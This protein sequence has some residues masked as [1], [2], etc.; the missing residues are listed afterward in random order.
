[1]TLLFKRHLR[2]GRFRGLSPGKTSVLFRI[3]LWLAGLPRCLDASRHPSLGQARERKTP[4]WKM[5]PGGPGRLF[6]C[7]IVEVEATR[8]H[9]SVV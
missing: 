6:S 4:A 3:T 5:P 1:L 8:R 2:D 9:R 7:R